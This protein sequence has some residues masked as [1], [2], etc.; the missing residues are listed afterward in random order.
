MTQPYPEVLDKGIKPLWG[1]R[2]SL[3]V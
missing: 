3:F 1:K 2:S